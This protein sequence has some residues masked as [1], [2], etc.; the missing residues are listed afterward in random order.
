[1]SFVDNK[2]KDRRY[3]DDKKHDIFSFSSDD[4]YD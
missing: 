4:D 3:H 2:L 1:M